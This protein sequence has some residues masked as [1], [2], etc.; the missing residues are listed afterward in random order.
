MLKKL[1]VTNEVPLMR[2]VWQEIG[3][4]GGESVPLNMK[5]VSFAIMSEE[6]VLMNFLTMQH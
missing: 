6:K 4:P 5:D 1:A 3:S 2:L